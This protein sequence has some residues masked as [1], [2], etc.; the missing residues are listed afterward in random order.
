MKKIKFKNITKAVF[1][2]FLFNYNL[3]AQGNL[4]FNQVKLVT[5]VQTVPAGKVWKVENCTYNGGALFCLAGSVLAL[6]CDNTF[7]PKV[8]GIMSYLING[9]S[10]NIVVTQG[11]SSWGSS[12]NQPNPFPLWLP[13]GTSLAAGTNVLYLSVI[14]FN[15]VP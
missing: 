8:W 9:N 14:E 6:P 1:I 15:V 12:A 11:S 3:R 4:Q 5:T 13:A 10:S 2:L 7:S